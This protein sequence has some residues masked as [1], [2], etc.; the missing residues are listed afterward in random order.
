MTKQIEAS[1]EL[2][3][4]SN[5]GIEEGA[6]TSANQHTRIAGFNKRKMVKTCPQRR[7]TQA[8]GPEI[9]LDFLIGYLGLKNDAALARRLSFSPPRISKIRH[10]SVPVSGEVLIRMHEI[11]SLSIRRLR[12]LMGDHRTH[13]GIDE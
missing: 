3:A 8:S 9:L 7:K 12:A 4:V 10:L 11:S 13:F 5:L 1:S 2:I 6:C